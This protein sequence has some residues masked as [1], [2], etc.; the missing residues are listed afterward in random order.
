MLTPVET[1]L[2]PYLADNESIVA[3]FERERDR[4]E[5]T[6]DDVSFRLSAMSAT[7]A[8]LF[9][10]IHTGKLDWRITISDAEIV[11]RSL[12]VKWRGLVEADSVELSVDGKWIDFTAFSLNRWVW[13]RLSAT[14]ARLKKFVFGEPSSGFDTVWQVWWLSLSGWINKLMVQTG[15]LQQSKWLIGGVSVSTEVD[16]KIKVYGS[17]DRLGD[18]YDL[19]PA[20]TMADLLRQIL[21]WANA[22]MFVSTE[23]VITVV[24]RRE[25]LTA[26]SVNIDGLILE[27]EDPVV[28]FFDGSATDNIRVWAT[29]SID[30][31]QL[32]SVEG[33]VYFDSYS[34]LCAQGYLLGGGSYQ[35]KV[36]YYGADQQP[37]AF[38]NT[39]WWEPTYYGPG[40][41]YRPT[42]TIHGMSG[43]TDQSVPRRQ[44]W[45]YATNERPYTWWR[46]VKELPGNAEV[47]W[48]DNVDIESAKRISTQ[49]PEIGFNAFAALI[50]WAAGVGWSTPVPES[51]SSDS[52]NV[53]EMRPQIQ[54]TN[55]SNIEDVLPPSASHL[56]RFFMQA[57]G[58][59]NVLDVL[60]WYK[61]RYVNLFKNRRIVTLWV[62]GVDY[63]VGNLVHTEKDARFAKYGKMLI[64][65]AEIDYMTNETKLTLAY[66][67][68]T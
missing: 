42:L 40:V 31:P 21:L 15:P 62:Q 33:P 27:S 19:D 38:S 20:M 1:D 66:T 48:T 47:A 29:S 68:E 17:Y 28:Q 63:A 9:D 56:F 61:Q 8:D 23:G 39:L 44:V 3:R 46:L 45:R 65:A 12:A 58:V 43:G 11:D 52:A 59:S 2:T 67:P 6:V 50:N 37:M 14:Q 51:Q 13:D 5:W 22:E 7:V 25:A 64:R 41:G 34:Q 18:L 54:F 10:S 49:I 4:F 36:C 53:Y 26:T 32:T 57:F 55:P 24:P 35:Y 16:V 30:A 60:G